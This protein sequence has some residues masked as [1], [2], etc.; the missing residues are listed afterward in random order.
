MQNEATH[1]QGRDERIEA[2]AARRPNP[3]GTY[4]TKVNDIVVTIADATPSGR[5]VLDKAEL[6]PADDYI[7]IQLLGHSSRSIELDE[8]VDLRA[9]GAEVFRAFKSDRIFRYTLN[10]HGFDW[11]APTIN[12]TELRAIGQVRDDEVIVPE[13]DGQET[14][15][16][17][18]DILDLADPGTEHLHSEK[19]LITVFFE[20]NPREIKRGVYTTEE[21]MKIFGVQQGYILEVINHEGNLTPLKPGEKLK[22][23]EGMRFFEQ[24]PCGGSS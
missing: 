2:T 12:E 18:G 8:T 10:G 20:N 6:K 21:L 16:K 23:K 19:R 15:L 9:P 14:D 7:L 3:D 13:R 4:S 11:G 1:G 24:V 5:L 22:V 17:P